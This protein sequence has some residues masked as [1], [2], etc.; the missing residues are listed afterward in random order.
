[1]NIITSTAIIMRVREFGESDLLIT[2][3]TPDRGKMNGIAKGAKRSKSR[4]V[5]CLDIF[6][7]VSL[8]YS[9]KRNSSLHFIH[10]GKLIDAFPGLRK[11]YRTLIQASYM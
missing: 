11:N 9:I 2:F 7:L 10:S 6:S 8:E 5:N 1:M 3:F 4:F